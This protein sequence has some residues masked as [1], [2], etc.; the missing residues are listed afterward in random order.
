MR[1]SGDRQRNSRKASPE[2]FASAKK[3]GRPAATKITT[4]QGENA[5]SKT[6]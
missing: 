1:V 2:N 6:E 5:N 4:A 3:E